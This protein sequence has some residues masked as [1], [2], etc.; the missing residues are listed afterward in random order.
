[1]E[2]FFVLVIPPD[3][4]ELSPPKC[5]CLAVAYVSLWGEMN[6]FHLGTGVL[7]R[8]GFKSFITSCATISL[9]AQQ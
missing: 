6:I 8:L 1:M 9:H 7:V 5:Q 3:T 4:L 2:E